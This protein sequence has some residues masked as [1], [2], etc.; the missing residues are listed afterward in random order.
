MLLALLSIWNPFVCFNSVLLDGIWVAIIICNFIFF[1]LKCIDFNVNLSRVKKS[2]LVQIMAWHSARVKP[3]LNSN[4]LAVWQCKIS[5][6]EKELSPLFYQRGVLC[7]LICTYM[8][9]SYIHVYHCK[10]VIKNEKMPLCSCVY[11]FIRWGMS[12][13]C[14]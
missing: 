10:Y 11:S 5:S 2:I 8:Y 3:Y 7:I 6:S 12:C 4:D 9:I 13:S 14:L 1:N